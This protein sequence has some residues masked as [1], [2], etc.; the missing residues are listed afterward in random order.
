MKEITPSAVN[1]VLE[2]NF[3]GFLT[4]Y[5]M[6]H[7]KDIHVKKWQSRKSLVLLKLYFYQER[8]IKN[9]SLEI[10]ANDIHFE[11][12]IIISNFNITYILRN[13]CRYTADPPVSC[14]ESFYS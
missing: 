10:L 1:I 9:V 2:T 4:N 13:S 6:M 11:K 7:S 5:F 8:D 3:Q 12:L 14:S